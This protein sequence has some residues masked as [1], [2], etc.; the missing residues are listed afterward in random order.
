MFIHN[1]ILRRQIAPHL[2]VKNVTRLLTCVFCR[3]LSLFETK[4]LSPLSYKVCRLLSSP[5]LLRKFIPILFTSFGLI[6]PEGGGEL[7]PI[8]LTPCKAISKGLARGFVYWSCALRK[9]HR[10]TV[11]RRNKNRAVEGG[12]VPHYYF[13]VIRKF[14]DFMSLFRQSVWFSFSVKQFPSEEFGI[15]N[16]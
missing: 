5:V 11:L 16:I 7:L 13:L 12:T 15:C 14:I 9:I 3:Y 10:S 2:C 6:V 4:L 8:H 1:G